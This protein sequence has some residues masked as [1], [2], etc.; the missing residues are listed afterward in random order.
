ME[1]EK[2]LCIFCGKRAVVK[3]QDNRKIVSCPICKRETELE[4]YKDMF[5]KWMGDVR[6]DE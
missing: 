5:Y 4:T 2:I 3:E 6:K 1:T